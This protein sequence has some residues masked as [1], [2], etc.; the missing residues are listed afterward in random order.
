MAVASRPNVLSVR[1]SRPDRLFAQVAFQ[2]GEDCF[3]LQLDVF[4]AAGVLTVHSIRNLHSAILRTKPQE[5]LC[6]YD[7]GARIIAFRDE[8]LQWPSLSELNY[9]KGPSIRNSEY[10]TCFWSP[11]PIIE[12][13]ISACPILLPPN[14]LLATFERLDKALQAERRLAQLHAFIANQN[15]DLKRLAIRPSLLKAEVVA[16]LRLA[17][18]VHLKARMT[19]ADLGRYAP[20]AFTELEAVC[21]SKQIDISDIIPKQRPDIAAYCDALSVVGLRD[22]MEI[23]IASGGT[24]GLFASPVFDRLANKI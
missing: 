18:D 10:L 4:E 21:A 22:R 1:L 13:L 19:Q 8:C 9:T 17:F 6:S 3:V 11:E 5:G 23:F 16:R 24:S 2:T 15:L 20:G 12:M 14:L 7:L